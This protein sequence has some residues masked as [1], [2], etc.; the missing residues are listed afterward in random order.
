MRKKKQAGERIKI[1]WHF[2]DG[3]EQMTEAEVA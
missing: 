1:K 2:E 3:A